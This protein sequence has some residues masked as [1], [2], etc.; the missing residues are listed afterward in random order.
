MQ[1]YHKVEENRKEITRRRRLPALI[2]V[3]ILFLVLIILYLLIS[4][5]VKERKIL[6]NQWLVKEKKNTIGVDLSA[7]QADVDM[8]GLKSQGISFV[9]IKATEGSSHQD[10][11]FRDNWN[12]AQDAGLL[13]GAY[14][15]FSYDSPGDTQAENFIRTVGHDIAG[16]LIPAVDVEYYGD[17]EENPPDEEDVVRELSV[18]LDALEKEYGVE[19]LIYTRPAIYEKYIRGSFDGYKIW[20]SSPFA[21]LKWNYKGDWYIWQYLTRGILEGY[22]GGEKYIDL[23][24]LNRKKSL[25]ELIVR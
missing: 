22:S 3:L 17:K 12:N 1:T 5:L 10:S 2:C 13:A 7:Y 18:F 9:Y 21:P 8:A 16:R 6:I 15:F 23:N 11:K 25:D 4:D 19:P 20:M 24:V 14:H